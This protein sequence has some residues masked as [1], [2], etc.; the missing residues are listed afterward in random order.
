MKEKNQKVQT[1]RKKLSLPN[2]SKYPRL[3]MFLKLL[4]GAV[5]LSICVVVSYLYWTRNIGDGAY[6]YSDETYE[7]IEELIASCAIPDVGLDRIP[8]QKE[9]TKFVDTFENNQTE[10]FCLKQDGYFKAEVTV[11][12]DENCNITGSRRN[13]NSL[14]EYMNHYWLDLGFRVLGSA[15]VAFVVLEASILGC[16]SLCAKIKTKKEASSTSNSENGSLPAIKAI[17]SI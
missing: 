6:K 4:L 2:L 16:M 1:E 11:Y 9:L 3:T 5:L 7:H 15:L 13:Y 12:M 8:L 17:D 10:L 14:Q